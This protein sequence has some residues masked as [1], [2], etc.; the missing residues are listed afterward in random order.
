MGIE[1][2][3]LKG[4][5]PYPVVPSGKRKGTLITLNNFGKLHW[6]QIKDTKNV[7]KAHLKE[8]FVEP[9]A[10]MVP[11]LTITVTILRPNNR[12]FDAVN[13]AIAVKWIEDAM[14]EQGWIEDDANNTIIL[15]PY[16]V[17]EKLNETMLQ[18]EV[19]A[20]ER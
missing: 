15:K 18:V 7:F 10:E 9:K 5:V 17:I 14:V 20:N 19:I 11:S 13:T 12:K 2:I 8:W 6:A 1:N 3:L 4:R 16:K